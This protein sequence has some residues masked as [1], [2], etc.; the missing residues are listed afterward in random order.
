MYPA[1]P[2]KV[3]ITEPWDS[4][5][6]CFLYKLITQISDDSDFFSAKR[7]QQQYQNLKKC[8]SEGKHCDIQKHLLGFTSKKVTEQREVF[9]KNPNFMGELKLKPFLNK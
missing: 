7:I 9:E 3:V 6:T 5:K 2:T 4:G 1:H 8:L